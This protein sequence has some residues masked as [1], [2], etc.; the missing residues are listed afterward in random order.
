[1]KCH[2]EKLPGKAATTVAQGEGWK[3]ELFSTGK[4]IV[5]PPSVHPDT[6]K[7]YTWVSVEIGIVPESLLNAP[8]V[9]YRVPKPNNSCSYASS[10]ESWGEGERYNR[11]F[12]YAGRLQAEGWRDDQIRAKV[13]T[14]NLYMCKPPLEQWEVD[15]IAR[16]VL[17]YRKGFHTKEVQTA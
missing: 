17:R 2:L 8:E 15:K 11:L 3:L 9:T 13:E 6:G 12:S 10:A 7:C 4:Q 14:M 5:V 1:M 16:S